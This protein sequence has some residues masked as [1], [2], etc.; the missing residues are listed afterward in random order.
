[1]TQ[2]P[3]PANQAIANQFGIGRDSMAPSRVQS[4][5]IRGD[6]L[7]CESGGDAGAFVAFTVPSTISRGTLIR[8]SFRLELA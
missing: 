2:T 8:R 5:S 6:P 4:P 7:I 3:Y 1:M